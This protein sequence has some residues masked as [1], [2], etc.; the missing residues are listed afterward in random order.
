MH[1]NVA[2]RPA[3]PFVALW[4]LAGAGCSSEAPTA[5]GEAYISDTA[6]LVAVHE[7]PDGV[8]REYELDGV[9][10]LGDIRVSDLEFAL[11]VIEPRY[12]EGEALLEVSN[13]REFPRSQTS[14]IRAPANGF[15]L[16][17]CTDD[18]STFCRDGRLYTFR[19][20]ADGF[21][22]EPVLWWHIFD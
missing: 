11:G 2:C 22:L 15:A 20:T 14:E 12:S 9:T 19:P 6:R 5:R 7:Y 4:L 10:Y 17:T 21:G 1:C 3:I 18:S 16:K 8:I 13:G